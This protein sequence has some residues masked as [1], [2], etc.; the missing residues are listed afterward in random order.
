VPTQLGVVEVGLEAST[1]DHEASDAVQA[2][3][4]VVDAYDPTSTLIPVQRA[5]GITSAVVA[6]TGGLISGQAGYVRLA[7]RTQQDAVVDFDSAMIAAFRHG[8]SRATSLLQLRE[9]LDDARRIEPNTHAW[10][11]Y[12]PAVDGVGRLDMG[13]LKS[14]ASGALPLAVHAH[15]AADLEALM[16]W[17]DDTAVE[18]IVIGGAEA[19]MVAEPLAERGIPVVIDPLSYGPG[20][21]DQVGARPDNGALLA[22]AGVS[23][24]LS[25]F[26]THNAR[27]LRQVAGNAVRGG[28][29]HADALSA[30]TSAPAHAFGQ[31]DRGT[32]EVGAVADLVLWSGYSLE[33]SS[34]VRA[35][36]VDGKHMIL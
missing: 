21:F 13:A 18:L 25:T 15:R 14:V 22:D 31:Q 36:F 8:S 11:R 34:S 6:P 20:G 29:L 27:T 19:W 3:L 5:A 7:G 12:R 24:V 32:I 10:E 30:I 17:T 26:S 23:V 9:L 28:M 2:A 1:R 4:R 16:R 33:L 35:V